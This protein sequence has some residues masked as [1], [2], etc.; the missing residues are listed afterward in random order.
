[1]KP[2]TVRDPEDLFQREA[3]NAIKDILGIPLLSGRLLTSVDLVVGTNPIPHGLKRPPVGF[4]IVDKT[5]TGD[6]WRDADL[7]TT[8]TTLPLFSSAAVT[9]SLWVF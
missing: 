7:P 8:A 1:M 2:P 6:I 4:F 9:V 5:A 3:R